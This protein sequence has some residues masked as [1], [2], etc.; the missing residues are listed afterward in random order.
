M[1]WPCLAATA[2]V[3]GLIVVTRNIKDVEG[4]GVAL[5]DPFKTRRKARV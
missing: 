3:Y 2:G 5:L 1:E 4:R